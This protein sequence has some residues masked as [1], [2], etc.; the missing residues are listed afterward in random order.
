MS[1]EKKKKNH[2]TK[3]MECGK[4]QKRNIIKISTPKKENGLVNE[5]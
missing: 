1:Q 4:T 2:A 3:N 5:L